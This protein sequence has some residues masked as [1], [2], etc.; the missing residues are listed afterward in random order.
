MLILSHAGIFAVGAAAF[1]GYRTQ[2]QF[3]AASN[4]PLFRVAAAISQSRTDQVAR[5]SL[6]ADLTALSSKL[7]APSADVI[8]LVVLLRQQR[9]DQARSACAALDWPGCDPQTLADMRKVV[10]P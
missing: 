7:R 8:R 1:V 2:A 3:Q 9:L 5:D 10:V 4:D 6:D